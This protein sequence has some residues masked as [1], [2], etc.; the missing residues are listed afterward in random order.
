[1]STYLD[2]NS[3]LLLPLKILEKENKENFVKKK[4]VDSKFVKTCDELVHSLEVAVLVSKC[5]DPVPHQ[6]IENDL[7][8]GYSNSHNVHQC[9][10][11]EKQQLSFGEFKVPQTK[12]T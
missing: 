2:L 11:R 10:L 4:F 6:Q 1:M 7:D 8:S 9:N 3:K 5:I 12:C